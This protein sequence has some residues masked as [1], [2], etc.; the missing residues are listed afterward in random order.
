MKKYILLFILVISITASYAKDH[1][2]TKPEQD[3]KVPYRIFDTK[4][5]YTKIALNTING[6]VYQVH[7][8]TKNDGFSGI[9]PINENS[10]LAEHPSQIG[11]FTLYE[12]DNM[13][14]FILVDQI[15]GRFWQA[16]W[17]HDKDTR[18]ILSLLLKDE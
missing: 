18:F 8:S 12:T 17:S 11:R 13:Y 10:L 1:D 4:N 9:L 5:M 16:Q 2:Q 3:I 6:K 7:F 15:S 14:S